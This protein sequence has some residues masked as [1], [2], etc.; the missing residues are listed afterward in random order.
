M[1]TTSLITTLSVLALLA[2]SQAN[3]AGP[4]PKRNDVL[5]AT[6][7]T[8]NATWVTGVSQDSG[9]KGQSLKMTDGAFYSFRNWWDQKLSDVR[10]IRAS[11]LAGAGTVNAGGSPRFSLEIDSTG[12]G[13]DFDV[14]IYLD[15]AYC[16]HANGDGWVE[17]DFTG[18]SGDCT[19]FD[20]TGAS[21]SS[22]ANGSA[23]SK[24][25]AAYP[26]AKVWFMF[27]IQDATTGSNYVD[28]IF[29]DSTFFTK[30]P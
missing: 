1:K 18:N 20:S 3:A 17:A 4:R 13:S 21:Y 5:H 8:E 25:V 16:G 26:N 6:P 12:H 27:L 19:I 14:V 2:F 15:P 7:D 29:L 22:D 30:Q 9:P 28:R 24:V 11:F 10:K 23:W